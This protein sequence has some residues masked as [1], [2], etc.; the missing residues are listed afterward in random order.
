[1]A[2]RV[3]TSG[4]GEPRCAEAGTRSAGVVRSATCDKTMLLLAPRVHG[5]HPRSA[6]PRRS[7]WAPWCRPHACFRCVAARSILVSSSVTHRY[8]PFF[9]TVT[10]SPL[11][12]VRSAVDACILHPAVIVASDAIPFSADGKGHPRGA[13]CFCRVL[14]EFV[15]ER[16]ALSLLDAVRKMTLLPARRL[17]AVASAFRRKGRLQPGADVSDP[18]RYANS[19]IVVSRRSLTP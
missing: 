2:Q 13:G 16:R 11:L 19:C 14:R 18:D 15:R 1:M 12:T 7:A 6:R 9:L 8:L 3:S 5:R 4:A 17:E 10:Y